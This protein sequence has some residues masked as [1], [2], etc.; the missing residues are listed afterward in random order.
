MNDKKKNL[1]DNSL[2]NVSEEHIAEMAQTLY[3]SSLSDTDSDE[4]IVV[5]E[6]KKSNRFIFVVAA[7]IVA[8]IG[9]VTLVSVMLLN[10]GIG[11]QPL[12]SDTEDYSAVERIWDLYHPDDADRNPYF[13][14][15]VTELN[16]AVIENRLNNKVYIDDEYLMGDSYTNCDSF[17]LSDLNG[18][19]YP[20][21]CIGYSSRN[22]DIGKAIAVVDYIKGKTVHIFPD[23]ESDEF[24]TDKQYLNNYYLYVK[25]GK[26]RVK[27][28]IAAKEETKR[29]G[30]LSYDGFE[31]SVCWDSEPDE[32]TSS[33]STDSNSSSWDESAPDAEIVPTA[34]RIWDLYHPDDVKGSPYISAI[35]PELDNALI[36]RE[37]GVIYINGEYP[38]GEYGYYCESIY[39]SDLTGD[40]KPELCIVMPLGSGIV[41]WRILIIDCTTR[42]LI[43]EISDR[44]HHDYYLFIRNGKLCVKET[45][46][47][48]HEALSTGMLSWDGTQIVIDWD[49][50]V[51]TEADKDAPDDRYVVEVVAQPT[52]ELT[53]NEQILKLLYDYGDFIFN[54]S[55]KPG[56]DWNYSIVYRK[57]GIYVDKG[58]NEVISSPEG[59]QT[60]YDFCKAKE[61]W[62]KE[63]RSMITEN[64]A[65]SF[66]EYHIR[67][68]HLF[69]YQD[70]WYIKSNGGGRGYGLGQSELIL[71]SYEK[72]DENTLILNF[73]SIGYKEE[74]GT[75]ED[76]IDEGQVILKKS[77]NRYRIEKCDDSVAEWFVQYSKIKYESEFYYFDKN[78][79]NDSITQTDRNNDGAIATFELYYGQ[80]W[81]EITEDE[82]QLIYKRVFGDKLISDESI[83]ERVS[84]IGKTIGDLEI[85][86]YNASVGIG[87]EL[88]YGGVPSENREDWFLS[89]KPPQLFSSME[90]LYEIQKDVFSDITTYEDFLTKFEAFKFEDDGF[91]VKG[92]TPGL[93]STLYNAPVL[94]YTSFGEIRCVYSSAVAVELDGEIKMAVIRQ[95][96]PGFTKDIYSV[97]IVPLTK[98]DGVLKFPR[99]CD[100]E[101]AFGKSK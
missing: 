87:N 20:E 28:T 84:Y 85:Q 10:G 35:I 58:T 86:L 88:I 43:Y 1:W 50:E 36:E 31:I 49:S 16:N 39:L 17:Y 73:V 27:E 71:N 53:E 101:N 89:K 8:L 79:V 70:E 94:Q 75:E 47:C 26:L 15:K 64:M 96:C 38:T 97:H 80:E 41:D 34:T 14:V 99:E 23:E 45:E 98:V 7:C 33:D 6:Q 65:E 25:N 83:Q 9:V 19:S 40:G 91:Y 78:K 57:D 4:L 44:S 48:K 21:L 68:N 12:E 32:D 30:V 29:T 2:N 82:I 59:E 56:K 92:R 52:E 42:K 74:W 61:S 90:E 66:I 81:R 51:N 18:D 54:V 22:S 67:N 3:K 95:N 60:H 55:F 46:W 13:S 5:E 100:W 11:V 77:E 72:P 24:V 37:D 93:T 62:I 69:I 76:L 63:L